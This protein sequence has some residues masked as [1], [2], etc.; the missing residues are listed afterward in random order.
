MG[1]K[2]RQSR[3]CTAVRLT[4]NG[5]NSNRPTP[6]A[7]SIPT[8]PPNEATIDAVIE[9]ETTRAEI[10]AALEMLISKRESIAASAPRQ[11]AALKLL[12]NWLPLAVVK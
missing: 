6:H 3:F 1:A 7:C 8:S 12:A 4:P 2:G 11:H 10:H 9:P 5:P